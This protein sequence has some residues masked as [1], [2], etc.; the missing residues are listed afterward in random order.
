MKCVILTHFIQKGRNILDKNKNFTP[1]EKKEYFQKQQENIKNTIEKIDN[2]V[3]AVFNSERFEKYLKFCSKFT[4]YSTNNI[5]LIAMQKLDASFVTSFKKWQE[6]GRNV[7]KGQHGIEILAPV[8]A[9]TGNS[10]KK[11]IQVKDEFGNPEFNKDGTIKTK[12]IEEPEKKIAFKKAYVFDISQ[13]SG[14]KI[15]LFFNELNSDIENEKLQAI[16][17]GI[18]KATGVNIEFEN[19]PSGKNGYYNYN[20]NRIT[21][22]SDISNSQKIKTAMYEAAHCLLHNFDTDINHNSKEIQAESTAFILADKYGMDTSEY[23]FPDINSWANEK[24]VSQLK[25][26]L[27][28]IQKSAKTISSAIDSE[29]LKLKKKNFAENEI[30]EDTELNNIQKAEILIDK[31]AD[32]GIKIE[33][34]YQNKIF[35]VAEKSDN[36]EDISQKLNDTAKFQNFKNTYGYDFK[37]I[38]CVGTKEKVLELFD[39]GTAV[40]MLYPDNTEKQAFARSDIEEFTGLFGTVKNNP[41]KTQNNDVKNSNIIGNTPYKKLGNTRDDLQFI[42]EKTRHAENIARQLESDGVKFS[43]LRKGSNTIITINKADIQ[44]YEQSVKKVMASYAEV[45]TRNKTEKKVSENDKKTADDIVKYAFSDNN[46]DK[47]HDV[48]LYN[49][50]AITANMNGET[51]KLKNS[52]EAVEVCR[53]YII[54]NIDN[55]LENRNLDK[56]CDE[57]ENK[58]GAEKALYVICSDINKNS[59]LY[60]SEAQQTADKFKYNNSDNPETNLHPN[61]I[62]QLFDKMVERMD[63]NQIMP[64]KTE[65][66]SAFDNKYLFPVEYPKIVNDNRGF[67]ETKYAKSAVNEFYVKGY[68]WLDNQQFDELKKEYPNPSALHNNITKYHVSYIDDSGK[69]GFMDITPKEYDLFYQ[70][71]NAPENKENLTN[72]KQKMMENKS[73]IS[74]K[75]TEYYAIRQTSKN[76]YSVITIGNNGTPDTVKS[77]LS[78]DEA[79]KA[80]HDIYSSKKKNSDI[81]CELVKSSVIDKKSIEIY[82]SQT[83]EER[84]PDIKY[85]VLPN[86]NKSASEKLSHFVQKYV[87]DGDKYKIDGVMNVGTYEECRLAAENLSKNSEIKNSL[88]LYQVKP[89]EHQVR[90]AGLDELKKMRTMPD[91]NNYEKVYSGSYEDLNIGKNGHMLDNIYMKFNQEQPENFNG[92][93][94]GISDVVVVDK[95]PYFIDKTNFALMNN[96]LPEQRI[97][98]MQKKFME[99]LPNMIK[100]VKSADDIVKIMQQGENLGIKMNFEKESVQKIENNQN[101]KRGV[102]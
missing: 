16:L 29:L 64:D 85:E 92:H 82:H 69:T 27:D 71:T 94:L 42:T 46:Y 91:F 50:S 97:E 14:K 49:N 5:M 89:E 57:L 96:F 30:I 75:K 95:K 44:A 45:K 1:E 13:T 58:F 86:P 48:P 66:S 25:N 81:R 6:L 4:D 99:N 74:D 18:K 33:R 84:E 26:F 56:F 78:K 10:I 32:T 2:T 90:F 102:L 80:M 11:E 22:N 55:A 63:I 79:I 15:P 70:K 19:I 8:K 101:K 38:N 60:S 20:E 62:K 23:S 67:P 73:D 34:E 68:G 72:A 3:K 41:V 51:D 59:N 77:N 65:L 24:E 31:K 43:G 21:I 40:Y 98:T 37:H 36:A 54:S 53:N 7:D 28:E 35:E 52:I 87:K 93:G 17:K 76:R 61:I 47:F 88:E 9:E 100:N 39:K 12:V 83:D